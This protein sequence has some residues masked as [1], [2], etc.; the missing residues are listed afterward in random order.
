AG[1]V[2]LSPMDLLPLFRRSGPSPTEGIV[3]RILPP[4]ASNWLIITDPPDGVPVTVADMLIRADEVLGFEDEHDLVRKAAAG[5]NGGQPYD[6]AGMNIA[7]IRRI[8]NQGLPATQAELIAEMQDWF[9]DQT[10][11]ARIP[12]SRSIRRRI[13]PIWHELRREGT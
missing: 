3:Q 2:T 9:A 12:D 6:W 11:G 1:T 13:T 7:L 8:H 5:T 4:D 10:G